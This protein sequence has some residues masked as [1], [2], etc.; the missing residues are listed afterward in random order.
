V[1]RAIAVDVPFNHVGE[2][3]THLKQLPTLRTVLIPPRTVDNRDEQE[4][5]TT[6]KWIEHELP[7]VKVLPVVYDFNIS[8]R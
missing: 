5:A 2:V 3:V 8:D 7:S 1:R 6:V 4:M